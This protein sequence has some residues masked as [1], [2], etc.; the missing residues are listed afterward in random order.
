V[1]QGDELPQQTAAGAATEDDAAALAEAHRKLLADEAIQFK[2]EPYVPPEVPGWLRW[3]ADLVEAASPV[4]KILF[5]VGAAALA[6]YILFLVYS[7]LSGLQWRRSRPSDDTQAGDAWR[8]AQAPARAL[9]REA[10]SLA[11]Q[12]RYSEA[13]HLL[14]FRSIE[15]IASRRPKLVRPA[16]TSRDIANA[17]ELPAGARRSFTTIVTLV[18]R[19]LFGGSSLL[20]QDWREC[21]SA[22]ERFAFAEAWR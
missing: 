9:L 13:A 22:Y 7:R 19:S 12:G 3:L 21:R 11:E 6:S 17:P 15:D 8:P 4:L 1:P 18:E 2:L 14:L 20:E 10:D 5:W 16:L